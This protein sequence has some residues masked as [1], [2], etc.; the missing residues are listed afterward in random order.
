MAPQTITASTRET[1]MQLTKAAR[2]RA[3]SRA[4][5]ACEMSATPAIPIAISPAWASQ[6]NWV[7]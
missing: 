4:P 3:G 6:K 5:R 7:T 1:A 2:A